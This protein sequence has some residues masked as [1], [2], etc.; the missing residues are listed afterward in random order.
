MPLPLFDIRLRAMRRDRAARLGP[1]LFLYERV[2]EDCLER[3]AAIP[4]HFDRALL[5]GCPDPGAVKRLRKIAGDVEVIDPGPLL[6]AA[7]GGT[8]LVEDAW[9]PQPGRYDLAVA[10][11][12]LD[13]INDLPRALLALRL[14]L[15]DDGLLVGAFAGGETLPQLRSAMRAADQ[16][17][18]AAVPHVHP[19]IEPSALAGLLSAAG[20]ERPVVDIDRVAVS[21]ASL[22][23][24]VVDLRRMAATNLLSG[25]GRR[26]LSRRE[27]NAAAAA[28]AAAG[29]G[30]RT[31][32]TFEILHLAGWAGHL[33][34]TRV[35]GR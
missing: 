12:T 27:R 21:Y 23:R 32:E 13:T 11:G 19:R 6:A 28:F 5:V 24:L 7:A 29:D 16:V 1:E 2:F 22:D 14:A 20:F 15:G 9:E 26:S 8:A 33:P 34:Q 17:A 30:E 3:I 18:G 31:I 25:R 10:I 4:R 35:T